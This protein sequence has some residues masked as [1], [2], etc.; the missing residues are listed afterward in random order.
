M[1][2]DFA[3]GFRYVIRGFG[4]INRPG[5]RRYVAV[6]LIVNVALFA[7]GIWYAAAQFQ[8]LL[9][10]MTAHL[11]EWL[12]WLRYLLWPLFVVTVLVV[13]FYTF[14]LIANLI[15]APFNALLAER[16]EAQ[17][18]GAKSERPG[19]I[20]TFF[21]D[22]LGTFGGELRKLGYL[23]LWMIPLL[24]LSFIPVLNLAAPFAWAVFSAWMLSI[25]YADYPMGNHGMFFADE[26][27]LMR[28]HKPLALGFGTGLMLMTFVPVLNFLAMPVGVAGATALWVDRLSQR[29]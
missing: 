20:G 18:R 13:V 26:R 24:I 22:V 27:A 5:I 3:S 7:L 4:L 14:T 12:D 15:A 10:W 1:L 23:A 6:P 19:G 29:D 28:R 25:E 17:L 11:P 9:Q 8:T 21:K 16:L 2:S